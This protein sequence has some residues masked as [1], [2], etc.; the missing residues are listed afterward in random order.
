MMKRAM[1]SGMLASLAI[2]ATASTY[3]LEEVV[4]QPAVLGQPRSSH[5][6]ATYLTP[7]AVRRDDLTAR[8]TTLIQAGGQR[9][10][11][12]NHADRSYFVV[13]GPELAALEEFGRALIEKLD[14]QPAGSVSVSP[15]GEPRR[16]GS[17]TCREVIIRD[18]PVRGAQTRLCLSEEVDIDPE[19]L[20]Q[21]RESAALDR[22]PTASLMA[23]L[24]RLPGYPVEVTS[25]LG[26]GG[27]RYGLTQRLVRYEPVE[28]DDRRFEVPAGYRQIDN[29]IGASR[30]NAP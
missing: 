19:L 14:P 7:G 30:E 8:T 6:I 4:E 29:P 1:L 18:R 12:I 11:V 23:E 22:S 21:L 16:V 24:R 15:P 9:I 17:W 3:R 25:E 20:R 28:T 27:L 13:Q 2:C 5:R 26:I 10:T